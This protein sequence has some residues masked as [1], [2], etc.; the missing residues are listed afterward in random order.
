MGIIGLTTC[1]IIHPNVREHLKRVG[2]DR[3]GLWSIAVWLVFLV[4]ALW[5]H[6][7]NYLFHSLQIHLPLLVVPIG[8]AATKDISIKFFQYI[9]AFFVFCTAIGTFYSAYFILAQNGD[10]LALYQV[11]KSAI[12]PFKGDHVRFSIAVIMAILF[13]RYLLKADFFENVN[14]SNN[15][16]GSTSGSVKIFKSIGW[17]LLAWFVVYVHLLAAK[18]GLICLYLVALV[19]V[20]SWLK[21]KN[22]KLAL[23]SLLLMIALPWLAFKYSATFRMKSHYALYSFQSLRNTVDEPN[24]SDEGRVISYK[25]AWGI[26]KKN[27][28]FGVGAGD[29]KDAMEQAY[30]QKIPGNNVKVLLPHNQFFIMLLVG[31]ILGVI[32]FFVFVM[33]PVT[34]IPFR[35]FPLLKYFWV[36][37]WV[38]LLVE[39]LHEAQISITL[40]I[41]FLFFLNTLA[42][43]TIKA[44]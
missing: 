32:I 15:Q 44:A 14:I 41:F 6:N 11:G 3:V 8:F 2:I 20:A 23:P 16:N 19:Q 17:V 42:K 36:L 24:I 21:N 25:L 40:H 13:L 10:V 4:S 31:G 1:A 30:A 9:L 27:L 28:L 22:W 34:T 12:T 43:K 39:P 26:A 7:T 29:Y 33:S 35:R 37:I 5:S 38:P 18:T